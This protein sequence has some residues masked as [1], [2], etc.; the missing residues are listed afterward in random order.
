MDYDAELQL[1]NEVLRRAYRIERRDHILDI[2][3]GSGQTT[4]EAARVAAAGSALGVDISAQMID[5]ARE[6]ARAEGFRNVAFEHADAQ[7]SRFPQERFDVAISRFGTMFFDD[8]VAAF[9][10]IGRALRPA[11]RLVMMVWQEHGRNEWSVSIERALHDRDGAPPAPR[12]SDPFSLADR[13]TVEAILEAAG[14]GEVIF[15]DVHEPV[16][17]GPDVAAALAWARGFASTREALERLDPADARRAV[18]RLRETLAEHA[19]DRGVW[20][21]SRAWVVEA[22]RR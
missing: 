18:E 20:L 11:G 7:V 22:R 1:H 21:D 13:A 16:F 8:P 2:G 14:F 15:T 17:Y 4:R 12:G 10:N 19:G 9:A 3:C 5:R 6:L